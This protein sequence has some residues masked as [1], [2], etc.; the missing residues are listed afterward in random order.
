MSQLSRTMM[1]SRSAALALLSA[2][3][4]CPA[5]ASTSAVHGRALASA[6]AAYGKA[7]DLLLQAT[8][9]AAVDADSARLL[10][11]GQG[12]SR[13]ERRALLS[14]H[15]PVSQTL[16]DLSRLRRH[17][18]LLTRYF[19]ALGRIA[20]SEADTEASDAAGDAAAALSRLGGEL[21]GSPLLDAGERDTI[22]QLASLTIQSVRRSAFERELAA[23][24]AAIDREIEIQGVLLT[25]VRRKLRADLDSAAALGAERD[26]THPYVEN[27]V[28]DSRGWIELRR[29]YLLVPPS[30]DALKSAS[31]AASKLRAAWRAWVSGRFDEAALRELATD[32]ETLVAFAGTVKSLQP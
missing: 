18:R 2:L 5:C 20:G 7:S 14:R 1:R 16:A 29:A 24:G 27:A 10:S 15:A 17:A 30:T 8:Q 23:R 6:G 28:S 31:D 19:E 21:K 13:E 4:L 26:V 3:L 22:S 11:E 25:A 12:L 32:I 9:E